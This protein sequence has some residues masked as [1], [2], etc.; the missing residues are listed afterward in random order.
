MVA[1]EKPTPGPDVLVV[2]DAWIDEAELRPAPEK[3][4]YY[5][6]LG[7]IE[8][9]LGAP[10]AGE[11]QPD[12]AL[13]E[14]EV[15]RALASQGFVRTKVG[16]PMPALAIIINWGTANLIVDDLVATDSGQGESSAGTVAYNQR[17]I[18]QLVGADKA[19]RKFLSESEA[20]TINEAARQDR[21]Y[22]L[23]GALDIQAL[24]KE[25]KKLLWRTRISIDAR[26]HTLPDSLAV[27]LASAAPYFGRET[28]KP[29]V[30]DDAGRRN[31]EVIIGTPTVVPESPKESSPPAKQE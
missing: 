15:E 25:Q 18:A 12:P 30:V 23:V 19:S 14:R 2:S 3:P 24:A 29:V 10:V 27:M 13:L 20:E 26:R 5:I 8:R 9:T 4:V 1:A 22:L 21:L 28:E 11:P 16:G 31:A 17:E 6:I 7:R